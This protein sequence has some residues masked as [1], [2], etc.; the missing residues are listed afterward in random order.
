LYLKI[1][2]Q[3]Q[4]LNNA[5]ESL[6]EK[7]FGTVDGLLIRAEKINENDPFFLYLKSVFMYEKKNYK[8]AVIPL[9]K[10]INQG[11]KFPYVHLLLADIYQYELNEPQKA[12]IQ[13]TIFVNLFDDSEVDFR[14]KELENNE[15]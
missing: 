5:A 10:I 14:I 2:S 6:E 8:A 9:E 3:K 1:F 12:L 15:I 13:L 7:R 4:I 11:Y